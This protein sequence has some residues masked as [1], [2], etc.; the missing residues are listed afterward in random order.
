M[1]E[2]YDLCQ[3]GEGGDVGLK[4]KVKVKFRDK[5]AEL[6]TR[7][8]GEV[9]DVNKNRAEYLLRIGFVEMVSAGKEAK[10][11]S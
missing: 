2:F 1:Q 3:Q 7:E 9:L 11:C 5:E 10:E 8:V 6:K 4:V